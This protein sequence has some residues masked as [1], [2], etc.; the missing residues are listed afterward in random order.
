MTSAPELLKALKE[1]VEFANLANNY[2]AGQDLPASAKWL[3]AIAKAEG[4]S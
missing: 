3:A 4:R 2:L 1:A